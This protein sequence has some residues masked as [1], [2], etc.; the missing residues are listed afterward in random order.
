MWWSK[1]YKSS[2]LRML[3]KLHGLVKQ[4]GSA[5]K[6]SASIEHRE[7]QRNDNLFMLPGTKGKIQ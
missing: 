1:T 4:F 7:R 2:A 3:Q 6:I 5:T